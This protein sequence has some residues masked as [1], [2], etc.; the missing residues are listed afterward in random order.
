[1][2]RVLLSKVGKARFAGVYREKIYSPG[3]S[4]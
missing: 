4:S 2:G 1:M 3:K